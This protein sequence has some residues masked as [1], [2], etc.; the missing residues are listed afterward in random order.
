[1]ATWTPG[2]PVLGDTISQSFSNIRDNWT[3]LANAW[4]GDHQ[5]LTGDGTA[6]TQ[7]LQVTLPANAGAI[8]ATP[9]IGKVYTKDVGG[10]VIEL[11][12]E[13]EAGTEIQLT[14]GTPVGNTTGE[15]ALPGGLLLKWG[16]GSITEQNTNTT[17]NFASA[18]GTSC[19]NVTLTGLQSSQISTGPQL[20]SISASG[21]V[22]KA[23]GSISVGN[24]VTVYYQAIGK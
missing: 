17:V 20:V 4:N 10:G 23:S 1:M 7:H 2:S 22:T 16:T 21:F 13:D 11:V 6:S 15:T 3:V 9:G 24:P 14:K 8:G 19:Y 18:F 12:Y 5:S